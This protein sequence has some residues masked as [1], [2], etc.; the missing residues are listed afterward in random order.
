MYS[1]LPCLYQEAPWEQKVSE[2]SMVLKNVSFTVA[3]MGCSCKP[4]QQDVDRVVKLISK[5]IC[6]HCGEVVKPKAVQLTCFCTAPNPDGETYHWAGH[7]DEFE[8]SEFIYIRSRRVLI[9]IGCRKK[10][11]PYFGS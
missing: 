11:F 3:H 6:I 9:H 4:T 5:D 10:A 7:I 8:S 1:L 2:P